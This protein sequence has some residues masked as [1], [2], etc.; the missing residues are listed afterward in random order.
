MEELKTLPYNPVVLFK[1]QGQRKS[2]SMDNLSTDDFLIVLQIQFQRD[3]MKEHGNAVIMMDATHG[4]TQH[5]FQLITIFLMD[6][7]G[8]GL[9]VAWAIIN[10]ENSTVLNEFLKAVHLRVG[11]LHPFYFMSDCAEQYFNSWCGVF[12]RNATQ[13]LL[14][15]WHVDRAW[16][17]GLSDHISNKQDRIEVYHQLRVLLQAQNESELVNGL[18]QMLSFLHTNHDDFYKYF[19][20]YYVPH[21]KQWAT[22]YRIR[23]LVNMNMF[24]EAF[25]HVLKVIYLNKKPVI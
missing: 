17:K 16:R 15:I 2:D 1:P 20:T 10:R 9:P 21:V 12:G 24:A 18:Q 25:H 8:S 19:N 11:D 4:T 23:T 22:C 14:C 5:D 3:A 13:K 7:H 6:E